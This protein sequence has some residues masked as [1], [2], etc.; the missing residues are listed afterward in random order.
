MENSHVME[1]VGTVNRRCQWVI[2][3]GYVTLLEGITS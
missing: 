1:I 3:R 2:V